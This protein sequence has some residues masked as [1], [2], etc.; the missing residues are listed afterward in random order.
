MYLTITVVYFVRQ[1]LITLFSDKCL[2]YILKDISADFHMSLPITVYCVRS[3]L[4]R[5]DISG[6]IYGDK[7]FRA[8]PNYVIAQ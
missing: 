1:K 8:K 5:P 6:N 7:V 2:M 4:K 3:I